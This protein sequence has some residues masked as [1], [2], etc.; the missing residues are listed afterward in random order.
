M[1]K[2]MKCIKKNFLLF[3]EFTFEAE[4]K[5]LQWKVYYI[6]LRWKLPF[7]FAVVYI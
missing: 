4:K 5:N 7:Q 6:L 2:N 1:Y 3:P